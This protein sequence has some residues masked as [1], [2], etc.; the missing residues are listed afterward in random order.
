MESNGTEVGTSLI[1][2]IRIGNTGS[3]PTWITNLNGKAYFSADD[4]SN[5]RELWRS[6][7]TA[8]GTTLLDIWPG[9]NGSDP[10]HLTRIGN[11]ILFSADNGI[12][13]S[14]VWVANNAT[15]TPRMMSEI[16]PGPGSSDP[17]LFFE[18]GS[19]VLAAATNSMV[20][21]EVWIAD[22]PSDIPTGPEAT[23]TAA[24]PLTICSGQSVMLQANTGTGYTYQWKKAGVNIAGAIQSNYTAT[25]SG[26]LYGCSH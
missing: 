22:I 3:N 8:A 9:P 26:L 10:S 17:T 15:S 18:Y 24:G 16:E 1:K 25:H 23:I 11:N 2:D 20:G 5:A 12:T 21:S 14:E 7:G 19:R 4:G 6:N 13:G